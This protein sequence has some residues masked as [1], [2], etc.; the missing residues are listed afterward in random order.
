MIKREIILAMSKKMFQPHISTCKS[1]LY[2]CIYF[3]LRMLVCIASI[4]QIF[5]LVLL[6]FYIWCVSNLSITHCLNVWDQIHFDLNNQPNHPKGDGSFFKL[7]T[8]EI[9]PP[10]NLRK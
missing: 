5:K 8:E 6:F 9:I 3:L 4:Y 10:E 2:V 1:N 7:N